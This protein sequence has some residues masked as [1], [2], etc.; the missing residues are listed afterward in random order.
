MR[1][2]M[3]LNDLPTIRING[4]GAI[5][6]ILYICFYYSYTKGVKEKAEVWA[7]L[8]Y[9]GA[10]LLGILA[11]AEYEDKGVLPYRFGILVTIFLVVL[12]GTPL[13]SLV[14]CKQRN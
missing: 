7:Q 2:G 13:L 6:H 4:I 12:V 11:Y 14:S 8:G 1:F 3:I 5:I 10:L 9:G